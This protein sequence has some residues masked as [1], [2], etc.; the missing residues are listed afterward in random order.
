MTEIA[1]TINASPSTFETLFTRTPGVKQTIIV[2]G[3]DNLDLTAV[4]LQLRQLVPVDIDLFLPDFDTHTFE[5]KMAT[6]AAFAD[7]VKSYYS[8]MTLACGIKSIEIRGGLHDW[9]LFQT[10]LNALNKLFHSTF[11][12][13][14]AWFGRIEARVNNIIEAIQGGSTEF[15]QTIFTATRVGSGSEQNVDGWF[16]RE[17]FFGE[18]DEWK[19]GGRKLTNFP[20]TWSIVPFEH[21]NTGQKFSMVQGCFYSEVERG[22]RVPGYGYLTFE[23]PTA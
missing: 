13:F 18:E 11:S 1:R 15:F 14:A 9:Q 23:M 4:C 12:P 6:M 10:H 16:G 8:Y 7:A 2:E 21:I 22:F 5:S 19:Y 3:F 17:F 20:N